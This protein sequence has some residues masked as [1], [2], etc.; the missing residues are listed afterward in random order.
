[1][2][3]FKEEQSVSKLAAGVARGS[4]TVT[5][6]AQDAQ[7]VLDRV[8]SLEHAL[9]SQIRSGYER[10]LPATSETKSAS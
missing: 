2:K 7:L 6:D 1:M 10:S 3:L 8:K 9:A 5:L 4:R